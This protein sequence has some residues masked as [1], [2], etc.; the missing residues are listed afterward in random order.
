MRNSSR[1]TVGIIA[2]ACLLFG[3]ASIGLAIP[4]FVSQRKVVSTWPAAKARIKKS[5]VVEMTQ[6]GQ[7]LWATRFELSFDVG[8]RIYPVVVNSYTQSTRRDEVERTATR[9]PQ[10]TSVLVRYNP[11]NPSD[12]RLDTDQP[13][14]FYRIPLSLA[15]T[16]A[17]FLV[18][19]LSLFISMRF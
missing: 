11:Q 6:S 7:K 14:R 3:L 13:R 16:G 19:A 5:D 18:T 4:F 12:I 9:F 17:I 10:G 8:N 2:A 15:I 1:A